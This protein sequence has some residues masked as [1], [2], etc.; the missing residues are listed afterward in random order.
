MGKVQEILNSDTGAR[1][2]VK[3]G[4]DRLVAE[5]VVTG[6]VFYRGEGLTVNEAVTALNADVE[7]LEA[8]AQ[9]KAK[10][11]EIV[12][13]GNVTPNGHPRTFYVQGSERAPYVANLGAGTCTCKDHVY[14]STYCKHLEAAAIFEAQRG[15][16]EERLLEWAQELERV[17]W[18]DASLARKLA[19]NG[20][21]TEAEREAV[22]QLRE[23]YPDNEILAELCPV[24]KPTPSNV[25]KVQTSGGSLT[26]DGERILSAY[27]DRCNKSGL[28]YQRNGRVSCVCGATIAEI[29]EIERQ[30]R[31]QALSVDYSQGKNRMWK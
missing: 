6:D 3:W 20:L 30:E 17:S 14:R 8:Q 9:R 26:M 5:L 1:L 24:A 19:K 4:Y 15:T 16:V 27:C 31:D 22:R 23:K 12:E 7:E 13:A 2:T 10:A 29:G 18:Y 25:R 21:D 28:A 11:R